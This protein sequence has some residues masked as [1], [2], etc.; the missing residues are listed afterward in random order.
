MKR[1]LK[2]T[3]L[4]WVCVLVADL[5]SAM[6]QETRLFVDGQ[7]HEV[8]I[9]VKPQRIVSLRGEQ[10]TAPLVELGAPIVGST[11]EIL[12]GINDGKPVIR[13]AYD[14]FHTTFDNSGIT[15]VGTPQQPDVER[16][17]ALRPDLIL[18]PD[19]AAE[20]YSRY[21]AVAPTVVINIWST[22]AR[23]R[24]HQIADAAGLLDEF[25]QRAAV[26]DFHMQAA[27][28]LIARSDLD[29]KNISVAVAEV[30]NNG[31][32]IYKNYGALTFVLDALGF[33]KPAIIENMDGE[34]LDLSPEQVQ[35]IDA[36]FLVS[37]YSED[38][39]ADPDQLRANWDRLIPGWNVILHAPRNNQHILISR[40]KMRALSFRAME[41]LLAIYVSNIVTRQFVPL[42]SDK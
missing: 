5:T 1:I 40:E 36:D 6:A 23:E 20:N 32:R 15:F 39:Y 19:F 18:V 29:P 4:F 3:I 7:G 25:E 37:T 30:Q 28:N 42:G 9:P 34:R 38:R 8:Q 16:I 22:T 24:Y 2:Y 17:A 11:G 26:F 21:A 14:L 13:G 10:F 12:R 27:R 41:E 31:F 35:S 33:A